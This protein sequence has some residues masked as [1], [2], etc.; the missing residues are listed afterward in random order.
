MLRSEYSLRVSAG[1]LPVYVAY[2][3][4]NFVSAFAAEVDDLLWQIRA[5]HAELARVDHLVYLC[6]L[7][8]LPG[9]LSQE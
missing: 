5:R 1:V 4:V 2:A 3:A 6:S 8:D 7:H 9:W